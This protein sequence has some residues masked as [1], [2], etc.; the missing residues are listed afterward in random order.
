MSQNKRPPRS[1]A[2]P[3]IDA[4]NKTGIPHGPTVAARP[5][6]RFKEGP[7]IRFLVICQSIVGNPQDGY[8]TIYGWDGA[9][10]ETRKA[11]IKAGW[12]ER[13]SD[14]FNIGVTRN[15]RLIDFCWMHESMDAESLDAARS[16]LIENGYFA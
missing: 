4:M 2:L 9:R 15:G 14:D 5:V 10:H 16:G 11:A 8:R 13:G 1:L 3:E 7:G 12:I 6:N